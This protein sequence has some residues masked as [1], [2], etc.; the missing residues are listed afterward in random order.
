MYDTVQEL[1]FLPLWE[2]KRE[3]MMILKKNNV[4]LVNEKANTRRNP[5]STSVIYLTVVKAEQCRK[6]DANKREKEEAEKITAKNT[7]TRK[8]L[9]QINISET[10][11]GCIKSMNS[12][13]SSITNEERF[14]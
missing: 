3:T 8:V 14:I 1:T 10:F 2:M 11:D 7:A 5:D 6:V 4:K 12:L 9:I 13:S